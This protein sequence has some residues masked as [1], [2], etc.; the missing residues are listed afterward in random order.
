MRFTLGK[1]ILLSLLARR[2][3]T[4]EAIQVVTWLEI[5]SGAETDAETQLPV[6]CG[7]LYPVGLISSSSAERIASTL[8]WSKWQGQVFK[9]LMIGLDGQDNPKP[10]GNCFAS[11]SKLKAFTMAYELQ[12][13]GLIYQVVYNQVLTN[14][15]YEREFKNGCDPEFHSMETLSGDDSRWLVNIKQLFQEALGGCDH[16]LSCKEVQHQIFSLVVP[17]NVIIYLRRPVGSEIDSNIIHHVD[18]ASGLYPILF[19]YPISLER[20]N[21][22][23]QIPDREW[24]KT[25][26]VLR[27]SLGNF[28]FFTILSVVMIG[29]MSQKDPRDSIHHGGWMMKATY[30][31]LLVI[32]SLFFKPN[33]IISFYGV[34]GY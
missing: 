15:K 18:I 21:H 13:D 26:A 7:C 31:F 5:S 24:F 8:L 10:S 1:Q 4:N 23:H 29:M 30:W 11:H 28:L 2:D 16:E 6:K 32:F 34:F 12:A 20:I 27:V 3:V 9:F 33:G 17:R 14:T 25:E 22:F 19:C